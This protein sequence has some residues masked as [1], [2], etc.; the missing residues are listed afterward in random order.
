MH[1]YLDTADRAAAES[2]LVGSALE[3][4]TVARVGQLLAESCDPVDD[5]R[6]SSAFRRA[7]IPRLLASVLEAAWNQA[8]SAP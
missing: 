4:S 8:E 2:L 3:A 5:V 6:A 1:L 7:L